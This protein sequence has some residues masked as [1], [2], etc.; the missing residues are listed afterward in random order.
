MSQTATAHVVRARQDTVSSRDLSER[1][2]YAGLLIFAV[3][4]LW[5]LPL[6]NGFWLDETGTFWAAKGT[7]T[8]VFARCLLW[9]SQ[10]PVYSAIAWASLH[11]GGPP[12]IM[13]RLPSVIAMGIAAY[14]LYRLGV[15]LV[16]KN[17]AVLAT[18]VF[19]SLDPVAFAAG[20]ARSYAIGLMAVVGAMLMLVRW[21]DGGQL[22]DGAGYAGFVALTW[23]MQYVFATSFVVHAIYIASARRAG[24]RIKIRQLLIVGATAMILAAPS[25]PH[26]VSML[27]TASSHGFA[28]SPSIAD[29]FATLAPPALLC[30]LVLGVAIAYLSTTG[31]RLRLTRLTPSHLLLVAAWAMVCCV[32]PFLVSSVSSTK[33][34]LPRYLLPFSPV[35]ALVAGTL[36]SGV[37]PVRRRPLIATIVVAALV[38]SSH[39]LT[40]LSHGGD[41]RRAVQTANS[42]AAPGGAPVL[43]R[44]GFPESEPFNWLGDPARLEYLFAPL[45]IYPVSTNVIPLPFRMDSSATQRLE[46]VVSS[47]LESKDRFVLVAMG[48]S[49]YDIWLAGRLSRAGF[50][51]QRFAGYGGPDDSLRVL[52]FHKH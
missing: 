47:T 5:I 45:T 19:V 43:I 29:L 49:S 51:S 8:E 44:S 39:S 36:I 46:E 40:D 37:H 13:M 2:T 30:G 50:T 15:R 26:V 22:V 33:V 52:L 23:H 9:P 1:L 34:F 6:R 11:L 17:A 10:F 24:S 16:D 25:A 7:L 41:W 12:E 42:M 20:D 3:V 4:K 35:L 21:I 18:L 31:F 14:L 32:V 38:L 27:R 28:G 48:D